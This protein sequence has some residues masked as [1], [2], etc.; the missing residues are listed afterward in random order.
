VEKGSEIGAH[1][2]P[3]RWSIR[4]ASTILLPGWREVP[5]RPLKA[6]VTEA[7]FIGSAPHAVSGCQV[8]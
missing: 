7:G 2:L 4:S 3:A 8:S 5:D 6:P 1:I